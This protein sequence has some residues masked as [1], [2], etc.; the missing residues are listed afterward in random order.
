GIIS[1]KK[2]IKYINQTVQSLFPLQLSLHTPLKFTALL[3]LPLLGL[4]G[5]HPFR[6]QLLSYGKWGTFL[7]VRLC[8]AVGHWLWAPFPTGSEGFAVLPFRQGLLMVY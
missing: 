7:N 5:S 4:V 1:L 6:L 2:H 3:Q 8:V